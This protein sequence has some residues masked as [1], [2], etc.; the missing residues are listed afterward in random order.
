M[1]KQR[2]RSI[3]TYRQGK[4]EEDLADREAA[5]IAV[6]E[7][8]LPQQMDEEETRR[9]VAALVTELRASGLKDMGRVMAA[10]KSATRERWISRWRANAA[11]DLLK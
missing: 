11:K 9:A 7:E 6:I 1:I 5:E 4:R 2:R 8:F 3:E 10:P